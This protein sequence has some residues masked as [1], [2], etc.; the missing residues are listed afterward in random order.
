MNVSAA[1]N[2]SDIR[3]DPQYEALLP[4]LLEKNYSRL[5]KSIV[6]KG[7]WHAITVNPKGTVLD[8]HHRFKICIENDIPLR[9]EIQDFKDPLLEK[10]FVI[11]SN[12]NRRHLNNFQ[13]AEMG[14]PLLVIEEELAKKR[15]LAGKTL[16]SNDPRVSTFDPYEPD[17]SVGRARDIVAKDVGLSSKTFQRAVTVIEDGP[18]DLKDNVR[19]GKTSISKAYR[20]V[21][22]TLSRNKPAP[23]PRYNVKDAVKLLHGDL[24]E[25]GQEIPDNSIDYIIT[26]PPYGK[27][28]LRLYN[29]LAILAKRVLKDDGSLIVM[30][31][32]SYLPEIFDIL[33]KQLIYN[34]TVAYLT[35]GGQSSQLW[36]R[37]VNSFW[38]PVLWFVKAKYR[39]GWLGDVAKSHTNEKNLSKW[40]QSE[41][42]TWSIVGRF[43]EPGDLILDPF[44]GTGTIGLIANQNKRRFIGIDID[45]KMIAIAKQRIL[46][47]GQL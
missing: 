36:D 26:D 40:Q 24:L 22:K 43:T 45:E 19:K 38:K 30:V 9:W 47:G 39:G 34:W 15:M 3:R 27:K 18:E 10:A 37:K 4:K 33:R 23:K 12:L 31:G 41:S 2:V 17:Q 14:I 44:M 46:G 6:A 29:K 13:K 35:P 42:G 8:G 1:L 28:Y 20:Q 5:E 25:K 11:K 16:G 32:Q 21:R 7:L